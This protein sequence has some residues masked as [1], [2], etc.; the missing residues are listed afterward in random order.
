MGPATIQPTR[1]PTRFPTNILSRIINQ[2]TPR[3]YPPDKCPYL[4]IHRLTPTSRYCVT[5]FNSQ[6]AHYMVAPWALHIYNSNV[7]K[8]TLETLL[9]GPNSVT[10]WT[11]V[12]NELVQPDTWVHNRVRATNTT[13]F[14]Q[15]SDVP[16][17]RKVVYGNFLCNH[18]L[19]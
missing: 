13:Q 15:K 6:V 4:F 16:E 18:R 5:T 12:S 19:L 11:A 10:W 1:A 14:I 2:K 8:K 3:M 9:V 17:N 7:K